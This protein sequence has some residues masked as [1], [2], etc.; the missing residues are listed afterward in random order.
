MVA[1]AF[2]LERTVVRT[3][4]LNWRSV[5]MQWAAIKPLP[6]VTRTREPGSMLYVVSAGISLG[7]LVL[8]GVGEG[9]Y[10]NSEE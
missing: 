10:L 1:V 5:E 4:W 6:P 3:R 9:A 7:L 2:A 8:T